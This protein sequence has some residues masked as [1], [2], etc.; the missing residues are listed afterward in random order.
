MSDE[1]WA[2][3]QEW[4]NA[5]RISQWHD[6]LYENWRNAAIAKRKDNAHD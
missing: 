3:F 4:I 2:A 6:A 1:E 5:F